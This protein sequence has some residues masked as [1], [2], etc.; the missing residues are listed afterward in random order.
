[1]AE[2]ASKR[3]KTSSSALA[4]AA[5]HEVEVLICPKLPGHPGAN[6]SNTNG[7]AGEDSSV[8]KTGYNQMIGDDQVIVTDVVRTAQKPT[9]SKALVR[10]G[11][12]E[13]LYFEASKVTA[14]VVTCGGLCP[15]LN[16]VVRALT[17][18]L[19]KLYQVNSVLGVRNGYLG[20]HPGAEPPMELT[21]AVVSDI[22]HHGG[23]VLGAARGGFDA[24]II[25]SSLKEWGVSML[26][27]IGGD[28]T[29]RG[30][31][32]LQLALDAA[33]ETVSIIGVPKTIDNDIGLIDRSFGF[34]TAVEEACK[35]IRSAKIE[36]S[37]TPNGVGI[38]KLM[39]R[40]AGF[41][42]AHAALSSGDADL[43]LIP[44]V[45]IEVHAACHPSLPSHLPLPSPLPLRCCAPACVRGACTRDG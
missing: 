44:E 45:D 18:T 39:G 35:A 1:M 38:V 6:V 17:E 3:S 5:I 43:C 41:I 8:P 12:R 37:C 21:P 30:A 32:K 14:A 27:I 42:A 23:T 19:R 24:D 34:N 29:H 28:G 16:D 9:T 40:S 2:P 25:R 31:H 11:P 22:H 15:G 33:G 20:F 26:F 13:S 10:G 7:W 4:S 36:A